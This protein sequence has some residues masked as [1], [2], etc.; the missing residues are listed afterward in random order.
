[1]VMGVTGEEGGGGV[2][3]GKDEGGRPMNERWEGAS[4]KA[5]RGRARSGAARS[6]CA[7]IA[8]ALCVQPPSMVRNAGTPKPVQR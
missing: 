7:P 2:V 3:G 1:M 5:K 6:T 4:G 8:N